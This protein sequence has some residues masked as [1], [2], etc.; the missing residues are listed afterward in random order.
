MADMNEPKIHF[1]YEGQGYSVSMEAYEKNIPIVLPDGRALDVGEWLES[2]PPQAN[3]ISLH[4]VSLF[5]DTTPEDVAAA[6]RG[7]IA[8]REKL[9]TSGA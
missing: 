7:V 1:S 4:Q 8:Q 9:N 6:V 2:Y 5:G 3:K